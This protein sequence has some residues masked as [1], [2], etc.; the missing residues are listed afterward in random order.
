LLIAFPNV[1]DAFRESRIAQKQN[2]KT[3]ESE[4]EHSAFLQNPILYQNQFRLS[5]KPIRILHGRLDQLPSRSPGVIE[6]GDREV[7]GF[8]RIPLTSGKV[9]NRRH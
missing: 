4:V 6:A 2:P 7:T 9:A 5:L 3:Q 1:D 8:E